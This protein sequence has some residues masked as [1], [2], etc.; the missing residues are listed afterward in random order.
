M[1][2][3][4]M[5]MNTHYMMI[6]NRVGMINVYKIITN[7]SKTMIINLNKIMMVMIMTALTV[8]IT[9]TITQPLKTATIVSAT[10]LDTLKR[11]H[12]F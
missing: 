6:M 1:L 2:N 5:M 10:N 12:P 7:V 4:I 9:M 8:T 11:T 3:M